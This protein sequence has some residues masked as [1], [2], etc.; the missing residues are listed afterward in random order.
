M[1]G[2]YT[3]K[4]DHGQ[5]AGGATAAPGADRRVPWWLHAFAGAWVAAM[6]ALATTR[7]STYSEL[8]QED[9]FVEW[10]TACLFLG[11]A[12][13]FAV[14]AIRGRRLLDG[15]VALFC[16]AAAGEEVSWGQRIFGYLPPEAF[17][18]RNAQQEAN[19][20]N[21]VEAFGQPKWTLV[22]ILVAYGAV[23]PLVART[24]AGRLLA[25]RLRGTVVP[26]ALAFWFA[27]AAV[28]LVW[29]PVRF[30]GEWIEALAGGLFLFAAPVPPA[31]SAGAAIASALLSIGAQEAGARQR[32]RPELAACATAE[33][34]ALLADVAADSSSPVSAGSGRLHRRL[35]TLWLNGDLSPDDAVRFRAAPCDEPPA[36]LQRRRYG[37]DPWGTAYWVEA[38]NEQGARRITVYSFGP[39]RRRDERGGDDVMLTTRR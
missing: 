20:H 8:M 28:I 11:A 24:Q 10:W 37:V 14:A 25:E 32:T 5:S 16:L 35:H 31:W 12:L 34:R 13:S 1:T 18:A 39:N 29:Y 27:I 2:W 23:A 19:L 15:G 21:L 33:I 17:L 38:V 4:A 3:R 26:D 30:T 7:E 6:L 36:R 22:A 9:R